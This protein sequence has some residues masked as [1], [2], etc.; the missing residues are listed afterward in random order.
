MT[1]PVRLKVFKQRIIRESFKECGIYPVDG[2]EIL[3]KLSNRYQYSILELIASYLCFY[4]CRTLPPASLPSSGIE[5]LP[6]ESIEAVQKDYANIF[7]HAEFLPP[8]LQRNIDR[9]FRHHQDL[10][11]Q[12]ATAKDTIMR[13]ISAQQPMNSS[14]PNQQI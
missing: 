6:L 13:M 9:I 12:L 8:E 5:N 14:N 1:R 4:G 11:D 10:T 7:K 3:S 2:S